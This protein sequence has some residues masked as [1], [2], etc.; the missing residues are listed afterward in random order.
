MNGS[1]NHVLKEISQTGKDKYYMFSLPC[2]I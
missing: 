2:G 1:R